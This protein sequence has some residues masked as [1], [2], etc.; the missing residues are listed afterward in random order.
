[1][2]LCRGKVHH[3]HPARPTDGLTQEEIKQRIQVSVQAFRNKGLHH[4]SSPS[5]VSR[6]QGIEKMYSMQSEAQAKQQLLTPTHENA[7]FE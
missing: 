6:Q 1:M 4:K 5:R 7:L 2:P 3:D